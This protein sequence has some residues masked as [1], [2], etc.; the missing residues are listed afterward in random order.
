MKKQFPKVEIVNRGRVV[1][2]QR[3]VVALSVNMTSVK[4]ETRQ[5]ER[6]HFIY[7]Q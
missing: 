5:G 7:G 1:A 2:G 4:S 6:N 3:V